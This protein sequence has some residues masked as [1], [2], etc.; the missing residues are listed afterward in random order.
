MSRRRPERTAAA[1]LLAA[2]VASLSLLAHPSGSASADSSTFGVSASAHAVNLGV[3]ASAQYGC[4]T[5]TSGGSVDGFVEVTLNRDNQTADAPDEVQLQVGLEGSDPTDSTQKFPEGGPSLVGLGQR[6]T[7]RVRLALPGPVQD[8]DQVYVRQVDQPNQAE[9]V[10]LVLP[11]SCRNVK[12]T[13]FGLQAPALEVGKQ[14]C[15][16]GAKATLPVTL[17]NPNGTNSKLLNNL[18]IDQI[19]YAVLLVRNDGVLAGQQQA[20][21]LLSFTDGAGEQVAALNQVAAI[22]T[23]YEVR[24]IGLDGAVVTSD[25]MK[26]NCASQG[27][28]SPSGS[29]PPPPPPSSSSPAPSSTP[30]VHSS[31]PPTRPTG[32]PTTTSTGASASPTATSSSGVP[33]P[34]PS[35]SSAPGGGFGGGGFGGGGAGGGGAGA[36]SSGQP[37]AGSATATPARPGSG[38]LSSASP[39]ASG[40]SGSSSPPKTVLVE[41]P[42][43]LRGLLSF[44]RD[45]ALVLLLFVVALSGLV[46]TTV[47]NARRR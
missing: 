37:A 14:S 2:L 24:V 31:A 45:V 18:N 8:G 36:G 16:S 5:E 15:G 35:Q 11:A 27:P 29:T 40:Q 33:V 46:G 12:P 32:Q 1:L 23:T 13:N 25:Q 22:P 17:D 6:S 44:Q 10:T 42:N 20:G 43:H 26:L 7:T 41:P 30:T 19:D 4:S 21:Q 34:S 9:L 38:P 47:V 3:S 39:S 28:P